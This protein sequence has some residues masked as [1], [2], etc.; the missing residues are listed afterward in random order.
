MIFWL[1]FLFPSESL[2]NQ[3]IRRRW[4]K[5]FWLRM[6]FKSKNA[7]I[8]TQLMMKRQF[9][10]CLLAPQLVSTFMFYAQH[11]TDPKSNRP[12]FLFAKS[13]KLDNKDTWR[14]YSFSRQ[15]TWTLFTQWKDIF[16]MLSFMNTEKGHKLRK[17]PEPCIFF[18]LAISYIILWVHQQPTSLS[19]SESL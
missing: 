2:I 15:T 16:T 6:F 8:A 9:V 10:R 4:K 13:G 18:W 5:A 17:K 3:H 14:Q 1:N 12:Y 19:F 7:L 11:L